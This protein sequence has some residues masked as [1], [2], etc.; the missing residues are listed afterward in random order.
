MW[1]I[2]Q[3]KAAGRSSEISTVQVFS[4]GCFKIKGIF[5][6]TV[7]CLFCFVMY[8]QTWFELSRVKLYSKWSEGK[9]NLLRVS[10]RLECKC[11]TEIKGKSIFGRVSARFEI[12]RVLI[13]GSRL[14]LLRVFTY[15]LTYAEGILI[16]IGRGSRL[17]ILA[18]IKQKQTKNN[19]LCSCS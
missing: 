17:V 8:G 6:T 5:W 9:R 14:F 15:Q 12:A 4:Q 11:M 13:V 7:R 3:R 10:R 16:K 18:Q 19:R 2:Y 1:K